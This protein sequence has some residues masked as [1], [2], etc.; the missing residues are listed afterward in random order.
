MAKIGVIGAGAFGSALANLLG[1]NGHNVLLWAFEEDVCQA[2]NKTHI[3]QKFL[4]QIKLEP[5]IHATTDLEAVFKF[6]NLIVQAIPISFL[7]NVL[8]K[9]TPFFTS[10][11]S[12]VSA[13]KGIEEDTLML[14]TQIIQD[15]LKN[16]EN[17]A[18][19]S[20][21]TF[22]MD[23]A[24]GLLCSATIA[25]KNSAFTTKLCK[26]FGSEHFKVFKSSDLVG[27]QILGALKNVYS[28]LLSISKGAGICSSTQAY[29]L[30]LAIHEMRQFLKAIGGRETTIFSPA[31]LAD[32]VLTLGSGLSR[33]TQFGIAL[34]Q[35]QP[36][37][38]VLKKFVT[39]PEGYVSLLPARQ[40]AEKFG[41]K[42]K[43]LKVKIG[44]STTI[45]KGFKYI[46]KM[47]ISES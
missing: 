12:M 18:T 39:P 27:V 24:Q 29:Q 38:E 43:I 40:L 19:I 8:T 31:G 46:S 21:P 37:K 13:T 4:G 14:P 26:I 1:R 41:L 36:E 23:L 42:L 16:L 7:R 32:F 6:S 22:S 35:G 28:L 2:I 9:A 25:S 44:T 17:I 47:I 11:H 45:K 34:G 15:V 33:N 10:K 20:G 5:Q 30:F 3:N